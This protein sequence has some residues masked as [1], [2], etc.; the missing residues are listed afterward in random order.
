MK[1][2]GSFVITLLFAHFVTAQIFDE[3]YEHWPVELKINGRIFITDGA[4]LNDRAQELLRRSGGKNTVLLSRESVDYRQTAQAIETF[5]TVDATIVLKVFGTLTADSISEELSDAQTLILLSGQPLSSVEF[6]ALRDLK[7]SLRKILDRGGMLFVDFD[8]APCLGSVFQNQNGDIETG[9]NLFFDTYIQTRF[10]DSLAN[11]KALLDTIGE[12]KRT[13]GLGIENG[14][15]LLLSGRSVLSFGPGN[16]TFCLPAHN[17]YLPKRFQTIT[18]QKNRRQPPQEYLVDLTEWRRDAIDRTLPQFPAENPEVPYVKDGTLIMVGGGGMPNGLMRRMVDIAGGVDK[19]KMVFVPCSQRDDVGERQRTVEMWERMGVKRATFI[20]TKDRNRAHADDAFHAAL[21][22]A[23][24]IWFGGGRQWNFA[25][26][27]YGTKTHQLMKAVLARG[28]VIGGSSAGASIQGRYLA[29]ATPIGNFRIM[30]P[31]YER[32]GLGFLSGVAIDQHFSERGRQKDMTQ[33]V[34]RYPQLLGIGLDEGTALVVTQSQAEVV[35]RGK[36][37]FYDRNVP[38]VKGEPD[39]V[40]LA[41]GS[42]YNL[43]DRSIAKNSTAE[44]EA[45]KN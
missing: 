29:R 12:H 44:P 33:L 36:V 22:D 15:S 2:I 38:V 35:G 40:A 45:L 8:L 7:P 16:A 5:K 10:E 9:L 27:Y 39:Y 43:A 42:I 34:D 18:Q 6:A 20:H 3:Q 25:D 23:T 21:K 4:E 1:A 11:R 14:C 37:F 24:G 17:K 31:G 26:S 41:A 30:A 19:A 13:V 32:G 28:G